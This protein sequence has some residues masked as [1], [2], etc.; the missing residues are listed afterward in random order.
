VASHV[1]MPG[2]SFHFFPEGGGKMLT[3]FLGA[4]RGE[5]YEQKMYVRKNTK[6]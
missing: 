5:K 6:K 4:R 1:Y 3:D 2:M